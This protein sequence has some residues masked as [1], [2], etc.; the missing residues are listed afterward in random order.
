MQPVSSTPTCSFFQCLRRF[1][2]VLLGVPF[3][4]AADLETGTVYAEGHG[5]IRQTVHLPAYV[6]RSISTGQGCVIW[7]REIQIHPSE[8]GTEEV[9][10]HPP[11]GEK[12]PQLSASPSVVAS[13][14]HSLNG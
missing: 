2:P 9:L 4:L 3:S 1:P 14:P 5:T 7:A 8:E 11:H 6:Y 10:Y 13:I 12:L